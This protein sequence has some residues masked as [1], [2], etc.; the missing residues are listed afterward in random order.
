MCTELIALQSNFH[1]SKKFGKILCLMLSSY[2]DVFLFDIDS[3]ATADPS[4]LFD[5]P[6]YQLHGALF[7]PGTCNFYSVN[8]DTFMFFG[9]TPPPYWGNVGSK[10]ITK[11]LDTCHPDNP[12]EIQG[13]LMVLDKSRAWRGMYMT[14]FIS[15]HE[16]YF[17]KRLDGNR[18]MFYFGFRTTKID[19]VSRC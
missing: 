8:T 10:G 7:W 5:S 1:V 2:R 16:H 17:N 6:S 3:Y 9:I 12:L 11:F 15:I 4:D 18:M 14:M 19:D 13:G